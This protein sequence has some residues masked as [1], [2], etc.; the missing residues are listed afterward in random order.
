MKNFKIISLVLCLPLYLFF[1]FPTYQTIEIQKSTI[2]GLEKE[3]AA[4]NIILKK[5]QAQKD[6]LGTKT[7]KS[8]EQEKLLSQIPL[9]LEQENLIRNMGKL[10]LS[11]G[12][13]FSGFSF[14][15]GSNAE[16][17]APQMN[18]G[19]AV[20]GAKKYAKDFLTLIENNDRFL[21]MESLNVSIL[22]DSKKIPQVSMSIALYAFAQ[23]AE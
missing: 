6:N 18:I 12:F 9:T 8:I 20:T 3:R 2:L 10:A 22:R 15:K 21:G 19:F 5:L 7:A 14:S 17:N 16:V 4:K 13:S 23:S 1:I 11:T